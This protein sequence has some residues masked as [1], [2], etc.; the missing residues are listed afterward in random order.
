MLS[1]DGSESDASVLEVETI[2]MQPYIPE[3]GQRA[4][5]SILIAA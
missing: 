5:S 3:R 4:V 2:R 1:D